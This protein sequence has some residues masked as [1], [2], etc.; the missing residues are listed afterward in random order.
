MNIQ[1]KKYNG[2]LSEG[3]LT[4]SKMA[5]YVNLNNQIDN[6]KQTKESKASKPIKNIEQLCQDTP[7]QI[8][9]A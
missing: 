1:N 7:I 5:A 2:R 6:E 8:Y 9:K 3:V 4:P